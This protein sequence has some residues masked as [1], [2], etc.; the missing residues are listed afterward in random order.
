MAKRFSVTLTAEMPRC[1]SLALPSAVTSRSPLALSPTIC[2]V[3]PAGIAPSGAPVPSSVTNSSPSPPRATRVTPVKRPTRSSGSAPPS[4]TSGPGRAQAVV[5]SVRLA[6]AGVAQ[7]GIQLFEREINV[8]LRVG[9]GNEGGLEGRGG[10][11]DAARQGAA[12][13]T[14]EQAG[15][16]PL[17]FR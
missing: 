10:E 17:R 3:A 15:V 12:V 11:E 7:G 4:G 2:Q 8:G 5:R 13:P 6:S 14:R 16:R 1:G 9:A